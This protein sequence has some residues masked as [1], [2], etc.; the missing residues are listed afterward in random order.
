MRTVLFTFSA[1]KM[2][3]FSFTWVLLIISLILINGCSYLGYMRKPTSWYD[4]PAVSYDIPPYARYLYGY[5]VC[6]DPG[7]GGLSHLPGYKRGPSGL[8]EAEVNLSV[9]FF[10]KDFLE[11]AGAKVI[12]TR[13][14][15]YFVSLKERSEIAN[16]NGVDFFISIHHNASNREDANYTSTW[17]HGDADY[18]PVN[19]DLA[20]Y[21]QQAVSEV[22]RL[23]EYPPTGLY[24]DMLMYPS[25]F[26]VLRR[27][28]V[29]GVLVEG[30]F[31]SNPREE[32]RL[33]EREYN[34]REAYGYFLGIA[35]YIYAG[36]PNARL[37]QPIPGISIQ[38]KMPEI[39][40]KVSDG[41]HERE[42][43]M[44]DRQQI[45]SNSIIVY[46]DSVEVPFRYITDSHLIVLRPPEPLTNGVHQVSVDLINYYGNHNLPDPYF[47]RVAPPADRFLVKLW[48]DS[49]PPDGKSYT[50]IEVLALDADSLPIA[51][52]D[53]I[54][55]KSNYGTFERRL[56]FAVNGKAIFYLHS[57]VTPGT[58]EVR[59]NVGEKSDST[60]IFFT[61]IDFGLVEGR[62]R[63]ILKGENLESAVVII[64]GVDVED[65]VTTDPYGHFFYKDLASGS[66]HL[67]F[68][69]AGY[70]V[71]R[72]EVDVLENRAMIINVDLEPLMLG[73]FLNRLFIIDPKSGG[74]EMG[75]E[76]SDT[77]S[78]SMLNLRVAGR[79]SSLLKA[80]GANVHLLREKDIYMS[81]EDRIALA[82]SIPGEGFYIRIDHQLWRENEP[83]A[84]GH[85]YPGNRVSE[86][87]LNKSLEYLSTFYGD[88]LIGI[89]QSKDSE[90]NMI[91]KSAISYELR[92]VNHP[93]FKELFGSEIYVS[94][95]S[96]ALFHGIATY[97]LER[98]EDLIS[99]E[100]VVRDE[101]TG[102]PLP[103]VQVKL[104]EAYLLTTDNN[105]SC[106]FKFLR[107]GRYV[108]EA[109]VE[110]YLK[111]SFEIDIRDRELIEV[112]MERSM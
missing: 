89:V 47:F 29:P 51:D 50:A 31:H 54:R 40:L 60:R 56:G 58:A 28:K 9:A 85:W 91:N 102:E 3:R 57:D 32:D 55:I 22:L 52:G 33:K 59:I 67:K 19:L 105:G 80:A 36:F 49:L 12:L 23:P 35:R 93:L 17:Y 98:A 11:R 5:K 81:V 72:R 64:K 83:F 70:F 77:L 97:L 46:L 53:T 94:S 112:E 78:T 39:K 65:T 62:I 69:K 66:Y 21:I 107:P 2:K 42:A 27:L 108:V 99:L 76:I 38:E 1:D 34:R 96:S 103:G 26:G 6:L 95:I 87:L 45:F 48:S 30:S 111:R 68:S 86:G 109:E 92:T 13:D 106:E 79:L 10:L 73:A 71:E 100:V 84:L 88:S 7:H 14:G 24:S 41:L 82:N 75:Y 101:V 63:D 104:G 8:R 90:I 18:A 110:G 25:G 4:L 74:S 20:R 61:D 15:D 43:W 44:L 16:R 37:L